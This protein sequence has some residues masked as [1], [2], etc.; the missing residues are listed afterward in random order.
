MDSIYIWGVL[1]LGRD[2]KIAILVKE[3]VSLGEYA[4]CVYG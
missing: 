4:S 3:M 2:V 1:P